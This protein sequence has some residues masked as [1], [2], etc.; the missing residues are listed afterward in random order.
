M[1]ITRT[2]YS[3]VIISYMLNWFINFF[4]KLLN[5]FIHINF[6]LIFSWCHQFF[7][8]DLINILQTKS[9]IKLKFFFFLTAKIEF[10]IE[11][12]NTGDI[13]SPLKYTVK[14]QPIA[15]AH[16]AYRYHTSKTKKQLGDPANSIKTYRCLSRSYH[17]PIQPL[18]IMQK[19]CGSVQNVYWL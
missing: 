13:T 9:F 2:Y 12:T 15:S 16:Q 14:Q 7:N 10:F 8:S 3:Y 5:Y 18:V 6:C 19:R 4:F 11:N 1:C 17:V